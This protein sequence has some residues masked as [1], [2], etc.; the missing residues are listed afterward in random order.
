MAD[1]ESKVKSRA[2]EPCW[3]IPGFS[4]GKFLFDFT[5]E[6]WVC[7][8]IYN[9]FF[10]TTA[11]D[12]RHLTDEERTRIAA[13]NVAALFQ[14]M[15][16]L[17][18][19]YGKS[20]FWGIVAGL[21]CVPIKDKYWIRRFVKVVMSARHT[22]IL[23]HGGSRDAPIEAA[24]IVDDWSAYIKG[25]QVTQDNPRNDIAGFRSQR[26]KHCQQL[27]ELPET[28]Q[29]LGDQVTAENINSSHG[30]NV[31]IQDLPRRFQEPE[32]NTLSTMADTSRRVEE[33]EFHSLS[34]VHN[35]AAFS[36][37]RIASWQLRTASRICPGALLNSRLH[38]TRNMTSPIAANSSILPQYH[39]QHVSRAPSD[40]YH[41]IEAGFDPHGGMGPALV[42]LTPGPDPAPASRY[43]PSHGSAQPLHRTKMRKIIIRLLIVNSI[44]LK[45][46]ESGALRHATRRTAKFEHQA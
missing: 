20:D 27:Q 21:R 24:K 9:H 16:C 26:R 6:R 3:K 45:A 37:S 40:H 38:L 25:F 15:F 43:A 46:V 1:L 41:S 2:L 11:Q 39:S 42:H 8:D 28:I 19:N 35:L 4:F 17:A 36:I 33:L 34:M 32:A 14:A 10:T 44:M 13:N 5:M 30:N 12:S 31:R 29:S 7:V 23:E 22:Y 18:E